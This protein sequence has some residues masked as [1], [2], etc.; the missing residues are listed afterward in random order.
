MFN[1]FSGAYTSYNSSGITSTTILPYGTDALKG[2][3]ITIGS[4]SYVITGNTST[5]ISFS[6][7]IAASGNFAI[8]FADRTDLIKIEDDITSTVKF[9][10]TLV[11]NKINTTL[12]H[13]EQK[14]RSYFK[15]LYIKFSD[16]ADPMSLI[17]NLGEVKLAFC[18][19]CIAECYSDTT[20]ISSDMNVYNEEKYRKKYKEIINDSLSMLSVDLDNSGDLDNIDKGTASGKGVMLSR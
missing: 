17:L 7:A 12:T 9:P 16:V 13:F 14:I 20:L 18:Y 1:T 15:N 8:A 2:W 19:Y 11:T 6:N 5:V 4:T 3:T 10:N